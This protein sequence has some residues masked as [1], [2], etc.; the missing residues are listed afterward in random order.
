MIK[1]QRILLTRGPVGYFLN[2]SKHWYLPGF[3]GLPLYDVMK[4]F[5]K[6]LRM[7]G[8]LERVA[9][10]SYNFIMALPPSLLVMI[11]LIP[12][13]P[14]F[15]N[16]S[17]KL[18]LHALIIDIIPAKQYNAEVIRF[19]DTLMDNSRIGLLSLGLLL[20]L[21]FSSNAMMGLMRAFNKKYIGFRK[22]VGLH[23][24]WIAIKL[25]SIIF[26]LLLAYLT[27]LIMQGALL[28]ILIKDSLWVDV[29]AYTRWILIIL[30]VYYIIGFIYRY[31]PAVQNKWKFN[32]P[33]TILA[34]FFCILASLGFSL[35]VD[36]FGKFNALYGSIGTIMLVMALVYV[37]SFALLI[38]FEL[39]VSISSMKHIATEREQKEKREREEAAIRN[40]PNRLKN[41]N[42]A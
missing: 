28:R 13:L 2:K 20:S 14:F 42:P 35:Y 3:E 40:K 1:I 12:Q 6:Q 10:I 17:L 25:I 22:R 32:S 23:Q 38:G 39:N 5:N 15:S 33:G 27:L 41:D 18:Q 31:A 4:F 19:V 21:W 11:T 7:H 37:N 24:R 36:N 8:L 26:S 29:I 16:K 9:A 30:L 34:T